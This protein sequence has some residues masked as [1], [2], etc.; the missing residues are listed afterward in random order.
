MNLETV[1][2]IVA[3]LDELPV[4]E[5][6]V[7]AGGSRIAVKRGTPVAA[8]PASLSLAEPAPIEQP[9]SVEAEDESAEDSGILVGSEIVGIFHHMRP[10]LRAGSVVTEGQPLGHIEA[11]RLTHDIIA[12]SAGRI[13]EVFLEDGRAVEYGS[14]IFRIVPE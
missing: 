10:P 4:A 6:E 7:S 13:A 12:P 14:V 5:I 9:A 11:M 3:I 1:E 2:R 8:P